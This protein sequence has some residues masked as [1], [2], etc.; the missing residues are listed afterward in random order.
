M[1]IVR[2]PG[3]SVEVVLDEHMHLPEEERAVFT[4]RVLDREE[5]KRWGRKADR[6]QLGRA[7]GVDFANSLVG[8]AL[9]DVRGLQVEG[10]GGEIEDFVLSKTGDSLTDDSASVLYPFI[11]ELMAKIQG[12]ATLR[13]EQAKNE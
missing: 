13:R 2:R 4:I 9:E 6:A 10:P 1:A 12:A 8:L 3:C 7:T 5:W 11:N